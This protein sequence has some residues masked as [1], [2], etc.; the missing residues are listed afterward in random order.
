MKRRVYCPHCR[1]HLLSPLREGSVEL[2]ACMRCGGLWFDRGELTQVIDASVGKAVQLREAL[3]GLDSRGEVTTMACPSCYRHEDPAVRQGSNYLVAYRFEE[4]GNVE[5]D[6]CETCQGLWLE[7]GELA[8]VQTARAH[9]IIGQDTSWKSWLFQFFLTLPVE[10]NLKPRRFPLVTVTLV[11]LNT[12][13]LLLM[14]ASGTSG[15]NAIATQWGLIPEQAF[16]GHWLLTTLTYGF[17]HGGLLH[18]LLNMY[19]LYILGDNVEDLLGRPGFIAF[20]M[21][22]LVFA[23]LAHT[24]ISSG[25]STPMVGASGAISGVMAAYTVF[26]RHARL[27][28]MILFWQF[29]LKATSYFIIWAAFNVF[30]LLM[31]QG[32]IAWDAHLGGFA[33]GLVI[34]LLL[35]KRIVGSHPYLPLLR[36]GASSDGSDAS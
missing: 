32:N 23:G 33:C 9:E 26:F 14:M 24:L 3:A 21:T 34:A 12:A 35:D 10:F 28:F 11:A 20:Y 36:Q 30:G 15:A 22:A 8:Q 27:T 1:H 4:L 2:D 29:K 25:S 16:S 7:K 19:F 18:L 6:V 17:L 13:L 31:G 5:I